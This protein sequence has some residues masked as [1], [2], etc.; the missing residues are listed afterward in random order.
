MAKK[1]FVAVLFLVS[2]CVWGGNYYVIGTNPQDP[3]RAPN[4][5]TESIVI[6]TEDSPVVSL[7][8]ANNVVA[9]GKQIAAGEAVVVDKFSGRALWVGRCGNTILTE[10]YPKGKLVVLQTVTNEKTRKQD[11]DPVKVDVDIDLTEDRNVDRNTNN[12]EEIGFWRMFFLSLANGLG[13]SLG[14]YGGYRIMGYDYGPMYAGYMPVMYPNYVGAAG[15]NIYIDNRVIYKNSFNDYSSNNWRPYKPV[16]P[17]GGPVN[18]NNP[19]WDD[20]SYSGGGPVNPGNGERLATRT[21]TTNG[22]NVTVNT[23]TSR[24]RDY[25]NYNS[26]S[27]PGRK[28]NVNVTTTSS[29]KV[30]PNTVVSGRQKSSTTTTVKVKPPV[31]TKM[32]NFFGGKRSGGKTAR[33]KNFSGGSHKSY[34]NGY[35]NR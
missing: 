5:A 1:F 4:P 12:D 26:N 32:K 6:L 7:M 23:R 27:L 22:N 10:W 15:D 25:Q 18:P 9:S 2:L 30:S 13:E 11:D 17:I 14:Y 31:L 35:K 19:G 21:R 29:R 34:Y 28:G 8:G 3:N 20:G 24:A 16:G 33:T